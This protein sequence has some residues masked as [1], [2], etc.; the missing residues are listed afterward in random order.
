MTRLAA[1][2][3]SINV[4]GNRVKMAELRSAM[5]AAGL[6]NVSTV[7]AS[8][9]VLFDG[10]ATEAVAHE[11]TIT[12]VLADEFGIETFAIVLTQA[13]LLASVKENPFSSSGADN[14]VHVMFLEEQPDEAAFQRLQADHEGRGR[15]RLAPGKRALHIDY[16]DGVG[17]SKLTGAFILKR[18]G[19][20]G[21]AR[22]IR[23]IKRIAEAMD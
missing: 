7:T 21:T 22:N 16:G 9:N 17:T 6:A 11:D 23:S 19:C 15:E 3:G 2:L 8:G 18:M 10:A 20:R 12:S 13:D 4:G 1:L 14:L 5:E